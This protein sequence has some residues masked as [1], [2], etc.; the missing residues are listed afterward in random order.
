M[1][2][3]RIYYLVLK[4]C[5]GF[6]I[7]DFGFL[8]F[9][10]LLFSLSFLIF[11][12]PMSIMAQT[13]AISPT[14]SISPAIVRQTV[15]PGQTTTVTLKITNLGS[16]P[17]PMTAGKLNISQ[18]SN[19]GAPV[20]TDQPRPRSAIDWLNVKSPDIIVSP[21]EK[22]QVPIEVTAPANTAPGGYLAAVIWQAKLPSF[23]FDLD[24]NAKV[25]PA[26]SVSFLLSIDG[27]TPATIQDLKIKQIQTPKFVTGL[28]VA[29]VTEIENPTDF[30]IFLN[31]KVALKRTFF[32]REDTIDDLQDSVIL[33]QSSRTYI[34][35]YNKS[36]IPNVYQASIRLGSGDQTLVASAKFVALPWQYIIIVVLLL[37]IFGT[38]ILRRRLRLAWRTLLGKEDNRQQP[39]RPII[40]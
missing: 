28:P 37:L 11:D 23:Y 3:F 1:L 39:N 27:G 19:D 2:K 34:A 12:Q 16:D 36:L 13:K 33:P 4:Y 38:L 5:F 7:S 9:I 35:A 14:L 21:G 15:K 10:F 40:R 17:I 31:G 8:R 29:V 20:F 32:S 18:I 30:F 25:L 24:A 26:L 6:R 22:R